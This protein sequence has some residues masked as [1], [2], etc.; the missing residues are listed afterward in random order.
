M[1]EINDLKSADE[2]HE[3]IMWHTEEEFEDLLHR[4]RKTPVKSREVNLE[5][6]YR[7]DRAIMYLL[8]YAGLRVD[9]VFNFFGGE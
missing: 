1:E 9:V 2:D 3:K 7:R 6:K 4:V 5:E 8:T